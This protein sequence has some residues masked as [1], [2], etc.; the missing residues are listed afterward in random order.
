MP[1]YAHT[2]IPGQVDFAPAPEPV[3]G[4]LDALIAIGAAPLEAR[5]VV[6]KGTGQTESVMNPFTGQP[7]GYPVRKGV[8]VKDV[9]A[10]AKALKGLSDYNV[11]VTGKGPAKTPPL[12]FDSRGSY[13]YELHCCLRAQGR[14]YFRSARRSCG[15]A[16]R[17]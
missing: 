16:R 13:G 1:E 6:A 2:L 3:R 4:F 17:S 12:E 15:I 7:L 11:L 5:I 10:I 14:V 9:A 8:K